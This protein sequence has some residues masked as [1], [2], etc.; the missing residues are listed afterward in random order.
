MYMYLCVILDV[1]VHLTSIFCISTFFTFHPK[2]NDSCHTRRTKTKAKK[3]KQKQKQK[4]KQKKKKQKQK[5]KQKKT[6]DKSS[7][8]RT[9]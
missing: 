5:Q 6:P 8:N 9:R 1:N 2:L 7:K 4:K 3:K